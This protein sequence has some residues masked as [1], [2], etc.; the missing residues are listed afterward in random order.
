MR[1]EAC[2][3]CG[4]NGEVH[5]HHVVPRSQGGI[6]T[7]PL[8]LECHGKVHNNKMCSSELV[9]AAYQKKIADFGKG[10]FKWG[11][12]KGLKKGRAKSLQ[13]RQAKADKHTDRL[14]NAVKL[15]D[16]N[17]T[18]TWRKRA[19]LLRQLGIKSATGKEITFGSLRASCIR[20]QNNDD[21]E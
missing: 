3:E 19:E 4:K 9:K 14:W 16:P 2:W 11:S 21:K 20:F 8:C 1:I 17:L 15:I 18:M 7:L 6:R 10:N 5:H 12:T 13:N